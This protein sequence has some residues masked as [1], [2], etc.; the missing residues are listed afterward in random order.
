MREV[1]IVVA[2]W[3]IAPLMGAAGF[4]AIE[5]AV[6]DGFRDIEHEA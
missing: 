4:L 6:H 2:L 3:E 1:L 5:R